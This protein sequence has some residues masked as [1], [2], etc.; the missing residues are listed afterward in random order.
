MDYT[1]SYSYTYYWKD[2]AKWELECKNAVESYTYLRL[3]YQ[4]SSTLTEER[5]WI[6]Y[7]AEMRLK[8]FLWNI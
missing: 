8:N 3:D 1:I 6:H 2:F 7:T 4:N 5:E